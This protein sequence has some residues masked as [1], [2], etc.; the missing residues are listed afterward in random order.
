MPL[1]V[2]NYLCMYVDSFIPYYAM[3]CGLPT[4][5][6][7][8]GRMGVGH[9]QGEFYLLINEMLNLPCGWPTL[10]WLEFGCLQGV[11]TRGP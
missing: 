10:G 3:H 9:P 6:Q 4:P 1:D 5:D 2:A 8:N 7:H 11:E